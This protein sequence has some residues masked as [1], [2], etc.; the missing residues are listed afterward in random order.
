MRSL[1]IA[2]LLLLPWGAAV[3]ADEQSPAQ[4][5]APLTRGDYDRQI[6]F[7][8]EQIAK[9]DSLATTFDRKATRLQ[10]RDYT[11]FRQAASMREE[12]KAIAEDLK[13]HLSKLE[14]E[15]DLLG[16]GGTP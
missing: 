14:Q 3:M 5:E 2:A 11:Q 10:S 6:S 1:C 4:A 16:K 8:K 9:Y 13:K 15:R 12:C 7:L